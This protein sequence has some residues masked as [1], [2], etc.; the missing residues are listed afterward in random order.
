MPFK[1]EFVHN[2]LGFAYV[3]FQKI[4]SLTGIKVAAGDYEFSINGEHQVNSLYVPWGKVPSS[5]TDIACK[6]FDA[7]P[8]CNVD[9]GYFRF[10]ASPA[11]IMQGHN[12]FGSDNLR[13]CFEHLQ[14]ALLVACPDVF[15]AIDWTSAE[16]SR[17][18]STYSVQL[19]SEDILFQVIESLR[20]VSHKYLRPS[21]RKDL[22]TTLYWGSSTQDN[23]D[24]GRTKVLVCYSKPHEMQH[25]LR[26]LISRKRKESTTRYDKVIAELSTHYIQDFV[27]NRLRFEGRAKKRFIKQVVGTCNVWAV[28]RFAE[29]HELIN[30]YSFCEHLFKEMFKDLFES[31]EGDEMTVYND[32]KVHNNLKVAFQTLTPKGNVSYAKADRL[33]RFYLSLVDRGYDYIARHTHK[34][35]LSR[36][37][38]DLCSIGFSKADL[39]TL[40]KKGGEKLSLSTTLNIDFNNQRPSDYVEPVSPFAS[41]S[42]QYLSEINGVRM[43]RLSLMMGL[44][45]SPETYIREA[46]SLSSDI[47]VNPYIDL[48]EVPVTPRESLSLVIWPDGEVCLSRHENKKFKRN[49]VFETMVE[50]GFKLPKYQ[51]YIK[52][53]NKGSYLC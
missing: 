27:A 41:M 45:D 29:K 34:S 19:D 23:P 9:W 18:D 37:I 22:D 33:F 14:N 24:A 48:N 35:T 31:L 1:P 13:L 21:N 6:V 12:V 10:K 38:K 25:Q 32:R 47:D 16:F 8:Q 46:L 5:Y 30:Q 11:K 40:K 51:T 26:N 39:Q 49:K 20:K 50:E 28:I 53:E 2:V 4:S 43:N 7:H 17:I 3:D 44:H 42:P 15:D 52:D 36:S